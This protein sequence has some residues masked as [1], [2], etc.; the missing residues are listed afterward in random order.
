LLPLSS[1]TL[2]PIFLCYLRITTALY[3]CPGEVEGL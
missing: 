3:K 2:H 1:F